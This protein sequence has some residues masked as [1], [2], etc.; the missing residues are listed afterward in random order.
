M[1]CSVLITLMQSLYEY[2]QCVNYT[3]PVL[4]DFFWFWS[5]A[6]LAL[7]RTVLVSLQPV[8][9]GLADSERNL[10]LSIANNTQPII[11]KYC[12]LYRFM[13]LA[14]PMHTNFLGLNM[15]K[16]NRTLCILIIRADTCISTMYMYIRCTCILMYMYM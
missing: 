11:A 2:V 9:F 16:N 3:P 5:R 15:V 8:F 1:K 14:Y 12:L 6:A 4:P 10:S 7:L 13:P